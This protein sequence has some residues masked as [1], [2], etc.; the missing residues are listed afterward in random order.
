MDNKNQKINKI[1]NINN[2]K[3]MSRLRRFSET[4]L[5]KSLSD[6]SNINNHMTQI[7]SFF[8]GIHSN[9]NGYIST[10]EWTNSNLGNKLSNQKNNSNK[11]SNKNNKGAVI[12]K[13]IKNYNKNDLN[14]IFNVNLIPP[15]TPISNIQDYFKNLYKVDYNSENKAK[16]NNVKN[17][18]G[19][20]ENKGKN[21]EIRIKNI[22]ENNHNKNTMSKTNDISKIKK[23]TNSMNNKKYCDDTPEEIHFYVISSIQGGKNME[24][25]LIKK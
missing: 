10:T 8:K 24:Y 21:K 3:D 1:N 17:K 5:L 12:G 15:V 23:E 9:Q 18:K 14:C 20:N 4:K 13:I 11:Q 25:N 16:K 6:Y 22:D 2:N 19:R 7:N